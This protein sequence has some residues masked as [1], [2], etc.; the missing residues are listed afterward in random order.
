MSV[1]EWLRGR[2]K[3][4]EQFVHLFLPKE[5]TLLPCSGLCTRKDED[6]PFKIFRSRTAGV[7]YHVG[8]P[9]GGGRIDTNLS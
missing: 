6:P 3:K 7:W 1:M 9:E 4:C 8:C 2:E 5:F